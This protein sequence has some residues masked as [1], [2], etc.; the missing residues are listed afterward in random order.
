[1]NYQLILMKRWQ[2]IVLGLC[3]L[4]IALIIGCSK[5][6]ISDQAKDIKNTLEDIAQ[7]DNEKLKLIGPTTSKFHLYGSNGISEIT[8]NDSA[9]YLLESVIDSSSIPETVNHEGSIGVGDCTNLRNEMIESINI[10]ESAISEIISGL[11]RSS[12]DDQ[13]ANLEKLT[14]R[15]VYKR[16]KINDNL[17]AHQFPV[18]VVGHGLALVETIIVLSRNTEKAYIFQANA[19]KLCDGKQWQEHI[20]CADTAGVMN[21][22]ASSID[23]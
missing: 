21:Q 9:Y 15:F 17:E 7:I 2:T 18:I 16:Y 10:A 8:C 20:L 14:S 23:Y 13:K 4:S 1:M 11:P 12:S 3:L 6:A 5:G 22:F 19:N